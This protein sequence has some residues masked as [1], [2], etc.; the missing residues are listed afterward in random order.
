MFFITFASAFNAAKLFTSPSH[1]FVVPWRYAPHVTPTFP[2]V[3]LP[4]H[5]LGLG[6]WSIATVAA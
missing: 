3:G 2:L 1:Y 4:R 6:S 5:F